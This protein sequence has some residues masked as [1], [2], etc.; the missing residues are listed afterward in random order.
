MINKNLDYIFNNDISNNDVYSVT[1]FSSS[2]KKLVE[3][4]FTFLKIRGEVFRP[5]FPTSG[6]I[7]FTLNTKIND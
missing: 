3:N 1:E 4:S 6:H 2:I 7:Y 5:S